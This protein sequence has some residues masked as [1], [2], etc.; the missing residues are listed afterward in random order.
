MLPRGSAPL[1]FPDGCREKRSSMLGL[2][3]ENP[4]LRTYVRLRAGIFL[5]H[6]FIYNCRLLFFKLLYGEVEIGVG[7][8]F[9]L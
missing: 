2:L 6:L 4:R 8:W 9:V 1:G 5:R 7:K 3:K